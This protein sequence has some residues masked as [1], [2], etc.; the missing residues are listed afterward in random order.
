MKEYYLYLRK[1]RKDMDAEARG[2]GETLARH[3]KTLLDFAGRNKLNVTKIYREVV[4]GETIASRP[5]MQKLLLEVEQGIPAGVLVMEVE[6][7]ARGDTKDQGIVAEAFKFGG[8]KIITPMKTYDPDN[9]FD[10]EYFEFGLFMSRREYK[11]INRRL[12]RGRLASLQE[13][14]YI[15][16]AAPYGYQK[17]KIKNAKGYT[18]E[19]VPDQANVVKL[20]YDLYTTGELQDDNTY[21]KLGIYLICKKLDALMIHPVINKSWSTATVKDILT[22]PTYTGKVRWQWRRCVK[23]IENGNIVEKRPKDKNCALYDGIHEAIISQEQFD[24]AQSILSTRSNAP[25]ASNKIL[26]N[27]LSGIVR[28]GKC[29]K[30]MTRI[31]NKGKSEY[32]SLM[33]PNRNCNNVSAPV[34]LIEKKLIEGLQDWLVAYKLSWN[35][36]LA[37][38][39]ASTLLTVKK[40]SI[41]RAEAEL[42]E[43]NS[44]LANTYTL[45]EKGIYTTEVF[46]ERNRYLTDEVSNLTNHLE[47]LQEEYR[48]ESEREHSRITYI[49]RVEEILQVYNSLDDAAAK[50]SLLKSVL[51]YATYEKDAP[52]RKG[53]RDNANFRLTLYPKIPKK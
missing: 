35:D 41:E 30:P 33:C 36:T 44:Q 24:T 31:K 38:N 7:L 40:E 34:Y 26:K 43:L 20:I 4:S 52:N 32:Y 23:T 2:E 46:L 18:L 15:A 16:G 49:P 21:K 11:S 12:Q 47:K 1:S 22:N 8:V 10:E 45:V 19:I 9:E 51:E 14:K 53:N 28:C 39:E 27:P 17:V 25:V 42:I 5:E 50:N 3:E 48:I 6:R 13:G 37:V 29:G